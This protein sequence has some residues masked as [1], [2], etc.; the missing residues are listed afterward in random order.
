MDFT[1]FRG[2][3]RRLHLG[4]PYSKPSNSW[5]VVDDQRNEEDLL[6]HA[7]CGQSIEGIVRRK[8]LKSKFKLVR[9]RIDGGFAEV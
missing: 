8:H 9:R 2:P 1:C 6:V 4:T 7:R 5:N 3:E